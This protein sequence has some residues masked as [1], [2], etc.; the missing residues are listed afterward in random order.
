MLGSTGLVAPSGCASLTDLGLDRVDRSQVGAIDCCFNIAKV[1]AN[2][3]GSNR[4]YNGAPYAVSNAY[5]S[6]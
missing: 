3:A 5:V 6:T 1:I 2:S 4:L